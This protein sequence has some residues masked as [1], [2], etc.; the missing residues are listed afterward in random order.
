MNSNWK[1][2][3][4]LFLTSQ[5]ISLFG[6]SLVQYAIMWHITLTTQSGLMMTIAIVCG[7]LPTFFFPR[8]LESGQALI[9]LVSPMVSAALLTLAS[10]EIIFFIDVI[11]AVIAVLILV[12]FLKVPSH[13]KAQEA[14]TTS[15]YE[16]MRQGFSYIKNH[17]YV[18]K[19]FLFCTFF[20]ILVSPVAFLTPLQVT[21]SFGQDVWRLTGIE[22]AFSVGMIAGG[23]IMASW[24]GFKNKIH[25]MTLS[26]LILGACT[27]ALGLVPTF[28]L[29]LIFMGLAGLV[30]PMFNT[31]S[32]V[33]LQEKVEGDYLG[34]VF[35][36]MGMIASIM[37]PLGM[38]IFG[39]LSDIIEIEWL[40]I[41]SGLMMF[42]QAF[43]LIGN[44]ALIEAGKPVLKL[45]IE[46][47]ENV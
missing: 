30:M 11:T 19:F 43:F 32:T 12:L 29:Y 22:I 18:K 4:I 17:D 2:N 36:V 23:L 10:I 41:F 21:R 25:S 1:R 9:M 15:Y 39:P 28:W 14:P 13:T 27:F 45:N 46:E 6:T 5:T 16:D 20:F 33:L 37:M 26:C 40:L 34:R 24:G 7:F 3:I 38:L 47:N 44:K 42:V 31:P 8:L 35:G